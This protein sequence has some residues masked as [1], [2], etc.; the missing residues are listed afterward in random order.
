V[1]LFFVERRT[2]MRVNEAVECGFGEGCEKEWC[3]SLTEWSM[4]VV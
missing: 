3:R 2:G 1:Y 4:V